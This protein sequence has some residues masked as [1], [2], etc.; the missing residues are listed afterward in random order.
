MVNKDLANVRSVAVAGTSQATGTSLATVPSNTFVYAG[1]SGG[2]GTAGVTLPKAA[3]GKVIYLKNA[4][5]GNISVWPASGDAI[6]AIVADSPLVVAALK[7]CIL[8]A[9]DSTTWYTIPLL[10]S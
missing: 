9:R 4:Y 1:T 2:D 10:P 5:N 6:N 8:V 3:E 7:S